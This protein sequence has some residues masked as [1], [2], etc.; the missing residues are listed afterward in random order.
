M[1]IS[2]ILC[3]TSF[4]PYSMNGTVFLHIKKF[5]NI[6]LQKQY[7]LY[8]FTKY[9]QHSIWPYRNAYK[10]ITY[11]TIISRSL[12]KRL[13]DGNS[14]FQQKWYWRM[15]L[16]IFGYLVI[17]YSSLDVLFVWKVLVKICLHNRKYFLQNFVWCYTMQIR[18]MIFKLLTSWYPHK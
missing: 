4:R 12:K 15:G 6:I 9:V 3:T 16:C 2:S 1:W 5:S 17:W 10:K 8:K 11:W 18:L 13:F 14:L 7:K